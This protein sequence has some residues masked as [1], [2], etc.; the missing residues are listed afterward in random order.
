MI[1]YLLGLFKSISWASVSG[2]VF[3]AIISAIV[4]YALQKNSFA[5]AQR[6]KEKD[7]F[8]VRKA[9]GL[10][11]IF[12]MVRIASELHQL[13]TAVKECLER[14]RNAGLRG[15]PFQAV[16]SIIPLPDSIH[17]SP[18]EMALL[19]SIDNVLFNELASLD[20]LHNSTVAIFDTYNVRRNVVLERLGAEMNGH[21]GITMLTLE[22]KRWLGPRAVELDDLVKVMV[23]RTDRDSKEVGAVLEKLQAVISKEFKMNL[24]FE[25]KP[26][27]GG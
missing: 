14:A 12:K 6:Q 25:K 13:G 3:G 18:D 11:L 21:I 26:G 24:R 16:S 7:R 2:I 17:F 23:Q 8:E 10:S 19:L 9:L 5:E 22:Q 27:V 15:S 4:S 20:Q 1:E